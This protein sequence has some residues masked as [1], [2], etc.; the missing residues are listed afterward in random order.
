MI[1]EGEQVILP[2]KYVNHLTIQQNAFKIHRVEF[3]RLFPLFG[4]AHSN[5]S[6][7]S[8]LCVPQ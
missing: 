2:H 4:T 5:T 1:L 3:T 8:T 6:L 7:V